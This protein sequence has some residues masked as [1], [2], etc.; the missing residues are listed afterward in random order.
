M[1]EQSFPPGWDLSRVQRL[2]EHYDKLSEEEQVA[3]DEE[4]MTHDDARATIEVPIRLLPAI[5]TLLAEAAD[6]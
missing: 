6:S 5:H 4:G 3:D 2:I 1:I